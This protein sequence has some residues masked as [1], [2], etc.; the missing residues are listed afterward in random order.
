MPIRWYGPADR[1]DPLYRHYS[2]VVD[3]TLHAMVFAAVSSG[4]WFLQGL[5][6]PWSHL[7]AVTLA[8]AL[9]LAVHGSVV[10]LLRPTPSP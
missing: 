10:L 9:L 5:R 3:L 8:W 1:D 2:R 7:G 4:L 6:H